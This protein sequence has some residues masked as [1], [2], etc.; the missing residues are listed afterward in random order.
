[1]ISR[2]ALLALI[3]S[4]AWADCPVSADLAGGIRMEQSDGV[5]EVYR[6]FKPDIVEVISDFQDGYI[7]RTLL[8]R[9]VYV[10]ELSDIVS[11]NIDPDSRSTFAFP[12]AT[13]ELPLPA[14]GATWDVQTAARDSY[15]IWSETISITWGDLTKVNYG[16]CSYDMI[17][18]TFA[19]RSDTYDHNEVIHY[20]PELG[21]GVLYSY[22]D[23]DM[24]AP[25][26]FRVTRISSV[27]E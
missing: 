11:G 17:P 9:G 14:A 21:L 18:G 8:G 5:V 13:A 27:K 4:P 2:V 7:S 3:A 19:Y 15:D 16:A 12:V 1:M 25:D 10:L 24:D 22:V 6:Q 20:L 26:F 23:D